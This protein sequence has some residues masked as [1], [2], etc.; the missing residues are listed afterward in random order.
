M[1]VIRNL[2]MVFFCAL[3]QLGF[4]QY[5]SVIN[6]N[7]P[8]FSESPYSVGS[9][10]YQFETSFFYRKTSIQ[11]TFSRPESYGVHLHFRTSF[12]SERLEINANFAYSRDMVAFKN[13]FTSHYY[14]N[15]LSD[16]NFG[17][18][19]LLYQQE[20]DDKTKEIRSW[21]QRQAFDW[22][23]F[24]PSVALYAGVNTDVLHEIHQVGN[25]SPKVGIL[26]QNDLSQDFIIVSN[27]F[28]NK[29][30]TENKEVSYIVTATY[31]LSDRWSTFFENQGVFSQYQNNSNIGTGLAYLFTRN[32]QLNASARF[33]VEDTIPGFYTSFGV[34]YRLNRHRDTFVDT[35][36]FGNT[37][38]D[39]TPKFN[40]KKGLFKRIF[41]IFKKNKT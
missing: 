25:A 19:Y 29:I 40:K 4:A 21:R 17:V 34:S 27:I 15:G 7:R 18:K 14:V 22:K 20:F 16:M 10:V 38:I 30:G 5:T 3:S 32:L 33:I 36:P 2:M 1:V 41:G 37:L 31:S 26:L 28:L 13:I 12:F 9:G 35:D 24:I 6:S 23:R 39:N 11:P 8:G